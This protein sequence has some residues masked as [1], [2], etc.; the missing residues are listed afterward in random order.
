ME[1]ILVSV[2]LPVYGVEKW[3]PVCL[4]AVLGQS[5]KELEVLAIDDASPDDCG[6][7]LDQYAKRDSRVRVFHLP[8]NRRQG[9][10]RNLGLEHAGGKYVYFLDPDDLIQPTALE[11]MVRAAEKDDLDGLFFDS[12]VIFEDEAFRGIDYEPVRKG[13]YEDRVYTGP[14]LFSA[15]WAQ[16]DWNV[17]VWRQLWRRAFLQEEGIRFS[18]GEHED[19]VFSVAAAVLAG[20]V[21]YL[22]ARYPVHRYRADSVMTRAKSSRDFHGY[23]TAFRA[24]SLL[25][26]ERGICLPAFDANLAHIYE[27]VQLYHPLFLKEENADSWFDNPEEL[28]TYQLYAAG[29]KAHYALRRKIRAQWKPLLTYQHVFLFGAGKI[30]RRAVQLLEETDVRLEGILVTSQKDN[31]AFLG[32]YPVRELKGWDGTDN[33]AVILAVAPALHEEIAEGLREKNCAIYR[34]IKGQVFSDRDSNP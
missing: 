20:R 1:K 34:Y 10:G 6:L 12:E 24:L 7:I 33:T 11:E 28:R 30:A 18:T 25:A 17:Y 32:E 3:L 9:Y 31:P 2:I 29:E 14:E 5:L 4:D 13:N 16:D 22:P 15:F 26:A 19:E 27:L 21:R 8:E 23:F